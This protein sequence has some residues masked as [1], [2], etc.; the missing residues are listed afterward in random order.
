MTRRRAL[1]CCVLRSREFRC[2]RRVQVQLNAG[3]TISAQVTLYGNDGGFL[4]DRVVAWTSSNGRVV[5][6]TSNGLTATLRAVGAVR[7]R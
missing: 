4:T 3:D 1:R 7:R 2:R 6:V 5:Q